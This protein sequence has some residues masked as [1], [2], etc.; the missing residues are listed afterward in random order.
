[1]F[2]PIA[3][4][5]W[6]VLVPSAYCASGRMFRLIASDVWRV[7][8][9]SA[10]CA[11]GGQQAPKIEVTGSIPSPCSRTM[12]D[13][14][15]PAL[16]SSAEN[17]SALH[18]KGPTSSGRLYRDSAFQGTGQRPSNKFH[19]CAVQKMPLVTK[20]DRQ[21]PMLDVH[22]KC[23]AW[24]RNWVNAPYEYRR[25]VIGHQTM[26]DLTMQTI[27]A[28]ERLVIG[29]TLHGLSLPMQRI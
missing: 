22:E 9:P 14:S 3:S 13:R 29:D 19:A 4:H 15:T 7:L 6:S 21:R 1:M 20:V 25:C 8:V 26:D 18:L 5:V 10:D 2:R 11:S 17:R 27:S 23:L 24:R 28:C 16:R 12:G